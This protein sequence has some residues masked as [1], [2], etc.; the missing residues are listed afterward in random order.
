MGK[1]WVDGAIEGVNGVAR[2]FIP[3]CSPCYECTLGEADWAILEK[4]MSCNMLTREEMEDGKTPTTPTTSSVIAGIQVQ[5]A[6]KLLH[7]MPVL[8]GRGYIFEGLNHSSY[9]VNYTLNEEC[10]SHE[11]YSSIVKFNGESRTTT[12]KELFEFAKSHLGVNEKTVIEFSR[13]IIWKL[14]CRNCNVEEE[15]YV[16]VGSISYNNGMCH[17]CGKI[18]EVITTHSYSGNEDFGN[19]TISEMGLPLF[20]VFTGRNQNKS[21]Q[22]SIEGDKEQILKG[23]SGEDSTVWENVKSIYLNER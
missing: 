20:D 2:V 13:D 5:E 16:P 12:L 19:K 17:S 6:I 7:G 1:P 4:R 15:L 9:T 22:I 8:Q 14:S 23:L 21:I 3:E 11:T 18:R 10:Q